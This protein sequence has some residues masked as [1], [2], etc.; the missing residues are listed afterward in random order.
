[1]EPELLC[2]LVAVHSSVG[3]VVPQFD[4]EVTQKEFRLCFGHPAQSRPRLSDQNHP[5]THD[6]TVAARTASLLLA[7]ALTTIPLFS[8]LLYF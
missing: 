1:M 2:Q 3:F 8:C 7:S 4:E 5:L 6:M